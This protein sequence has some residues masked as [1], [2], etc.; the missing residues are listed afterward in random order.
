M[1]YASSHISPLKTLAQSAG[2][3]LSSGRSLPELLQHQL[4]AVLRA[5]AELRRFMLLELDL[6]VHREQFRG[7]AQRLSGD[8]SHLQRGMSLQF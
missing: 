7:L 1:C 5:I 6:S 2:Y 3:L 8:G 4:R